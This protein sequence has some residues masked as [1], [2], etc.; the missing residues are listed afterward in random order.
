[1]INLIRLV[2]NVDLEQMWNV[3]LVLGLVIQFCEANRWKTVTFE[4]QLNPLFFVLYLYV[5]R[6]KCGNVSSGS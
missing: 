6:L 4:R 2:S 1:M 5:T 3:L